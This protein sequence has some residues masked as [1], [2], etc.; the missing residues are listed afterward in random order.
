[1]LCLDLVKVKD[2]L[3]EDVGIMDPH[4][5]TTS[6][7]FDFQDKG[8]QDT[9][10]YTVALRA[11]NDW[12][13]SYRVVSVSSMP[14]GRSMPPTAQGVSLSPPSTTITEIM[15]HQPSISIPDTEIM[16]HQPSISLPDTEILTNTPLLQLAKESKVAGKR[17]MVG[18]IQP[19]T[20]V[21]KV[22][23][24][25]T[26]EKDSLTVASKS[27]RVDFNNKNSK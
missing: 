14:S 1:M 6:F 22:I 18:T 12:Y 20:K 25:T 4:P 9:C 16:P 7:P 23:S 8:E 11:P 13:L 19:V 5:F 27:A 3:Q 10:H 2:R 17:P 15:P 21:S 26:P 24:S